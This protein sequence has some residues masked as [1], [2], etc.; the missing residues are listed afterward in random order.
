MSRTID[1][2]SGQTASA[3]DAK[4]ADVVSE[5]QRLRAARSGDLRAFGELVRLKLPE[6]FRLAAAIL[7]NEADAADA[8]QN[9]FI[10]AWRE[11]ARSRDIDP[12][13]GWLL[14]ILINECRMQ[15][16][17][18]GR[19]RQRTDDPEDI[20]GLVG[21]A[22]TTPRAE[23]LDLLERAFEALEPDDRVLVVLYVL[24]GRPLVEIAGALH[25]PPG[26]A[27]VRLHEARETLERALGA[28]A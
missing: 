21:A 1:Q 18:A 25:M 23:A 10:A 13:D 27:K 15:F 17:H 16:R 6:T 12:F 4:A 3:V 7:G 14:K 24:E 5:R 22:P 11:L 8:T 9:V 20:G 28:V 26:T 19:G 2:E